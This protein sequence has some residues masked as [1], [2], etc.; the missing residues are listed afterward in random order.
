MVPVHLGTIHPALAHFTIGGLPLIVIAY[1]LA[2]KRRSAEWTFV[3]DAALFVTAVATVATL[4]FGLVSDNVVPWPGGLERWRLVHLCAGVATAVFLAIL[5]A[6]RF[7]AR[8]RLASPIVLVGALVIASAAGL[9]GY[10]GGDVLVFHAGMAVRAAGDGALSAPIGSPSPKSFLDAMRDARASWG[11]ITARAAWMT[12]QHPRDEDFRR[13][14]AAAHSLEKSATFMAAHAK[15]TP[16]PDAVVSMSQS[17]AADA[18]ELASAAHERKLEDLS[19]ALGETGAD[20]VS[21][22]EEARW[23]H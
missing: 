2:V 6:L 5:A 22:H 11:D 1:A 13:I 16:K 12:V 8:D 3:G 21:C 19:K 23:R 15:E 9:T 20:C 14:E 18:T 4:A 10:V 7:A 17:L